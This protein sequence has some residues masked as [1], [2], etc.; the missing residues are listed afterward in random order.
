MSNYLSPGVY[1]ED[2]KNPSVAQSSSAFTGGFLGITQR[3]PVGV[4]VLV[5][6]W[7][8]FLNSFAY[9]MN[10]PFLANSDLAYSVY[11]FFQNGGSRCYVVRVASNT[12]KIATAD[13]A[14]L[15]GEHKPVITA[16]DAGEWGN[17]LKLKISAN[18]TTPENFDIAVSLN[19][20][21]VEYLQ[22]L[23]NT[24]DSDNYWV[25]YVN[26]TSNFIT[27][28][29][30]E[31]EVVE[32]ITFESGADG[33]SDIDDDDFTQ[34]LT[35]LDTYEDL[36]LLCVPGQTSEEMNTAIMTYCEGRKDVFAIL[37]A[38]K[39]STVESVIALK[40]RMSCDNAALFF[41]WIR[42]SDYVSRTGRLRD[43]PTCGHVMGVYARVLQ[44]SGAWRAPA[45]TTAVV[46][47][48]VEVLTSLTTADVDTL[49]PAGIISILPKT[50]YGIVVWGARNLSSNQDMKY[51]SDV[52]LDIYIK[53][54]VREATQQFVFEPNDANTWMQVTTVVQSFLDGLWRDGA[55]AG[56]TASQAYFVKCDED[57]NPESSRKEGKLV[58]EV[59]YANKKPSEFVIFRFSHDV[60]SQ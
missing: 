21:V 48:A 15:L 42:V 30:G 11:G 26:Y 4:P 35:S 50:N 56:S 43:C 46:R 53:K 54:S 40:K 55:L 60:Q 59:G 14:D 10:T 3:G 8:S 20:E 38:P 44:N 9:G 32:S 16:R 51:V 47:G 23:S 31:L 7:N 45:G 37:D 39:A 22:N 25:D 24:T 17:S 1:I 29:S 49:N 13:T 19:G 27:G 57:L 52:L 28:T 33:V 41:P 58:C 5:T 6:S 36:N 34:A 2:N 12:A 18:V